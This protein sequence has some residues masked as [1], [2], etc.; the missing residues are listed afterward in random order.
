M[1]V[2]MDSNLKNTGRWGHHLFILYLLQEDLCFLIKDL[3][4]FTKNRL[5]CSENTFFS[6]QVIILAQFLVYILK[7]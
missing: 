5:W 7:F 4:F 1:Q 2:T 3:L 6:V